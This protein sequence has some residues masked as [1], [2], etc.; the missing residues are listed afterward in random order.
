MSEA[1]FFLALAIK[2]SKKTTIPYTTHKIS[3]FMALNMNNSDAFL[4]T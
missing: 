1:V 4:S 3:I 2:T